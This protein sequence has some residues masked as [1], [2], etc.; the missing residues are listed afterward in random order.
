MPGPACAARKCVA[1]SLG[2]F[3]GCPPSLLV[4]VS[5]NVDGDK[6]SNYGAFLDDARLIFTNAMTYNQAGSVG[7]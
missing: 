4:V 3:D 2:V 5:Q 7:K 6:Y 1:V